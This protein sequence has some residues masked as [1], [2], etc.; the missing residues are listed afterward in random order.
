[1]K[2]RKQQ[3][4]HDENDDIKQSTIQKTPSTTQRDNP[5]IK[6]DQNPE[7]NSETNDFNISC[8]PK[9][10]DTAMKPEAFTWLAGWLAGKERANENQ[11][12]TAQ[13]K[14]KA[15]LN[16][17]HNFKGNVANNELDIDNKNERERENESEAERETEEEKK[18]EEWE[19]QFAQHLYDLNKNN[20]KVQIVET[21]VVGHAVMTKTSEP[22]DTDKRYVLQVPPGY[23]K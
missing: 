3:K 7:Q 20:S 21:A 11:L 17:N 19:K 9:E 12:E 10:N 8:A 2:E 22:R 14:S 6:S 18:V 15:D 4:Q 16:A 23:V 13:R 5:Q 1:M